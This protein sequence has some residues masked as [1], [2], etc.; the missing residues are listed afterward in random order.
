MAQFFEATIRPWALRLPDISW[1]YALPPALIGIATTLFVVSHGAYA[2]YLYFAGGMFVYLG[3]L[4]GRHSGGRRSTHLGILLLTGLAI[5]G[6]IGSYTWGMHQVATS[7]VLAGYAIILYPIYLS[8]FSERVWAWVTA[9][10]LPHAAAAISQGIAHYHEG[11]YRATGLLF[12]PTLAAGMLDIGIIYLI[13]TRRWL[14]AV[15][16]IVALQLTASRLSIWVIVGILVLM[17][18][19]RLV[20]LT[21]LFILLATMGITTLVFWPQTERIF[22]IAPSA[23]TE[24]VALRFG[25]AQ[26]LDE[27]DGSATPGSYIGWLP[28]GYAGD[29]GLHTAP[30]R[31]FV[32]LGAVGAV[33]W[34]ALSSAGLWKR[35]WSLSWWMLLLLLGLSTLDYYTIMI[36]MS[37]FWLLA[38]TLQIKHKEPTYG[39]V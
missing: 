10:S 34:L 26:P 12:N 29:L 28:Q 8:N 35:R 25:A 31:L 24:S 30:S 20:P 33:T 18:L 14:L 15:P 37:A 13:F 38:I 2:L 21:G 3:L 39:N 19:R 5:L 6:A 17:A 22:N 7:L 27:L 9:G 4:S 32:Q 16:L 11:S 36:P 1:K 23:V